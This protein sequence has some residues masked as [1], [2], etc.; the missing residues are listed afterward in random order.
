MIVCVQDLHPQLS[1]NTRSTTV[2]CQSL[3]RV[4]R[5]PLVGQYASKRIHPSGAWRARLRAASVGR[6][7]TRPCGHGQEPFAIRQIPSRVVNPDAVLMKNGSDR[8]DRVAVPRT[9]G[10]AGEVAI[11]RSGLGVPL[12]VC[13]QLKSRALGVLPVKVRL[14]QWGNPWRVLYSERV[15]EIGAQS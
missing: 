3:R 10:T 7:R 12:L 14:V 2:N 11:A 5:C 15:I 13:G 8:N 4:V 9:G 1:T 6:S